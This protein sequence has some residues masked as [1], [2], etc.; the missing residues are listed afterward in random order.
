[1]S[2]SSESVTTDRSA[3][4]RPRPSPEPAAPKA[5]YH[6][7]TTPG[8]YL[9]VCGVRE[10]A[11]GVHS[12]AP[13]KWFEVWFDVTSTGCLLLRRSRG[14]GDRCID[15]SEVAEGDRTFSRAREWQVRDVHTGL[16]V[17][18]GI[19]ESRLA[20]LG[21]AY[22]Q[23]GKAKQKKNACAKIAISS[24]DTWYP[25]SFVDVKPHT[26]LSKLRSWT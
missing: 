19:V 5:K 4:K 11:P 26:S 18:V 7:D 9:R 6:T 10:D 3:H 13:H 2:S 24:G 17:T 23:V 15:V 21:K 14:E 22:T 1:M 20:L 25:L 12:A 16:T 8:F